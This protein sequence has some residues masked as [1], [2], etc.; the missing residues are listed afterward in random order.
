VPVREQQGFVWAWA[1]ADAPPE[2]EPFRFPHADDPAYTTVRK[3]V[4]ADASVHAVVEN[5]L[6]VPHTSFLHGGLFRTDADRRPIRCEIRRFDDRV[7]CEFFGERAPKGLAARILSPT[8]GE[9]RHVDRF[10]L[11]SITEVEYHLGDD[12][13]VVLNG[14][15]TPVDDL[16]TQVH[17]VVSIRT[18]LPRG[19]VRRALEPLALRIFRQDAVILALQTKSLQ[20]FPDAS[21]V[22]T[23][24]DVLGGH[25][26]RLLTRAARGEAGDPS[27]PPLVRE[28]TMLV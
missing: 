13:H 23:D 20:T 27:A 10:R 26:L 25:V 17:A 8:G 1:D 18:R 15:C 16:Q 19:L 6:D 3:T 9:I 5:A 4:S 14:A 2:G 22:S 28:T 11:P 7:E 12:H 24:V 21:F